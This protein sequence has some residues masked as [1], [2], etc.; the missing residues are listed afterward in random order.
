VPAIAFTTLLH[1]DYHTPK[2]E[3]DRINTAKVTRIARWMYLTGW[4]IANR[5]ERIKVDHG[6][7]L[8]R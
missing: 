8:E 6:F 7:K 1:A 4:D 3:P 5:P 2:D